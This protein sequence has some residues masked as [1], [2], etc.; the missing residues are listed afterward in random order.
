MIL[1]VAIAGL[2]LEYV[3][4]SKNDTEKEA[5]QQERIANMEV[6]LSELELTLANQTAQL[7]Q[8]ERL[9]QHDVSP[10]SKPSA[11]TLS[12]FIPKVGSSTSPPPEKKP[13]GQAFSVLD[14][15]IVSAPLMQVQMTDYL[16]YSVLFAVQQANEYL[17][18]P[19]KQ[20]SSVKRTKN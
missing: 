4:R 3:R 11:S 14:T 7:L 2:A 1:S 9:I 18:A 5:R 20:W 17:V 19:L 15:S 8:L 16:L 6:Q 12:K 10:P 13:T